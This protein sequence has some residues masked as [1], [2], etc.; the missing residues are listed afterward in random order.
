MS[1]LV[2]ALA[3]VLSATPPGG[4]IV[5]GGAML[6]G[7]AR[8]GD[9]GVSA[10][11]PRP[12]AARWRAIDG[13]TLFEGGF[14]DLVELSA[15]ASVRLRFPRPVIMTVCDE[16][17]VDVDP[18]RQYVELQAVEPGLTQ[19][20]FWFDQNPVPNRLVRVFVAEPPDD[21]PTPR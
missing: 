2:G 14:T 10:S 20:G 13:G 19:C 5:D 7:G 12:P 11:T 18:H 17:I 3:L 1:K 15:D 16:P 6:D 8:G 9:G 4:R 21:S